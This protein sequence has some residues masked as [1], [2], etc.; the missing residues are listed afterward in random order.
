M[1]KT[2]LV[3]LDGSSLA[4]NA[5]VYATPI[6]EASDSR[7]VLV[8]A[9]TS[10]EVAVD[11][12]GQLAPGAA[13]EQMQKSAEKYLNFVRTAH[14]YPNSDIYAHS[15]RPASVIL[16]CEQNE[17]A[18][19]IV[20][21]TH[22]R[23]GVGRWMLGSVTEKVL[24]QAQVP[25]LVVRDRRPI[26]R[27]LVPLDGSTRAEVVLHHAIYCATVFNAELSLL[28]V[29]EKAPAPIS[30]R[31]V[32]TLLTDVVNPT[33][34]AIIEPDQDEKYLDTIARQLI[35]S[36]LSVTLIERTGDAAETILQV[37]TGHDLIAMST[38]GYSGLERYLFGSVMEKVLRAT[39][40][41]MLIVRPWL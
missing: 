37:G 7:M 29:L 11:L 24:Q 23:S 20:M 10:A 41:P 4:E 8:R 33:R 34:P 3:P 30:R 9:S 13:A 5:L 12:F 18:D 36:E 14:G 16:D 21:S 35:P 38:H 1:Y 39:D 32:A 6:A 25:L 28:R 17:R 2:V 15:G 31:S 19:L 40:R 27:I 22:G 26:Q